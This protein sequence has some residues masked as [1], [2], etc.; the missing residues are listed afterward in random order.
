M[1]SS[2]STK[3][4]KPEIGPWVTAGGSVVATPQPLSMAPPAP[5]DAPGNL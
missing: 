2:L 3:L 1:V 4:L 5:Y